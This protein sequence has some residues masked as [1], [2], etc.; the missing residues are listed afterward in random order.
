MEETLDTVAGNKKKRRRDW[1]L[2]VRC[3]DMGMKLFSALAV[4]I[5]KGNNHKFQL[6]QFR[7]DSECDISISREG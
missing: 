4:E 3:G 1:T 6:G 7:L 5:I 2:K